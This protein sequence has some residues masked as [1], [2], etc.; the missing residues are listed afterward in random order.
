MLAPAPAADG[1]VAVMQPVLV[2]PNTTAAVASAAAPHGAAAPPRVAA[3]QS[4]VTQFFVSQRAPPPSA[5]PPSASAA[6]LAPSA[7]A[8]AAAPAA[9]TPALALTP[10]ETA[11]I[12]GG[13]TIRARGSR[14]YNYFAPGHSTAIRSQKDAYYFGLVNNLPFS[15]RL[16]CPNRIAHLTAAQTRY[17]QFLADAATAATTAGST[18]TATNINTSTS[19]ASGSSASSGTSAF[20]DVGIDNAG[21]SAGSA[22]SSTG[23]DGGDGGSG[24]G[25]DGGDGCSNDRAIVAAVKG[26][27]QHLP[28]TINGNFVKRHFA[29]ACASSSVPLIALHERTGL[30][31]EVLRRER[32]HQTSTGSSWCS[33][34]KPHREQRSDRLPAAMERMCWELLHDFCKPDNLRRR[35]VLVAVPGSDP[36]N[37]TIKECVYSER[38][39]DGTLEHM[40]D[41][42]KPTPK[43]QFILEELKKHN[44]KLKVMNP[45]RTTFADLSEKDHW[46]PFLRRCMCRYVCLSV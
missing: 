5:A 9:P 15:G 18:T 26:Y 19:N 22:G 42:I 2:L 38:D 39:G 33:L 30:S 11:S 10:V 20:G 3:Y 16:G 35:T 36:D 31:R 44:A 28:R 12:D 32:D 1:V 13:W 45:K 46:R 8:A 14:K 23:A 4:T 17:R 29:A 34:R 24:S 7:A 21:S 37:P 43:W 6:S 27:V 41:L 25:G 40:Y